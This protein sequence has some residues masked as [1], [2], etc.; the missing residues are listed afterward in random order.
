MPPGIPIATYRLQ[1]SAA[2]TFDDAATLV[3]YLKSLGIS[4]L[5]AS[6]FLKARAGS[7]HGYD[8]VDHNQINPEFGGE[9]GFARLSAAL[10]EADIGLI[11]DFVP[12][13]MGIGYADNA[14]WLD[15]LEWGEKS[16]Y[17]VAFDIEWDLLPHRGGGGVLLPILGSPYGHA[18]ENGD[19]VLKYDGEEGSFSAWYYEHRLP[20]RPDR[21]G[22]MLR[23]IVN[24]AAAGN[25]TAGRRL[26]E[27]AARSR[28]PRR[29]SRAEAPALKA[30]LAAVAGGADVIARGIHIYRPS[31]G[32][33]DS[34]LP[35]HRLLERQHYRVAHWRLAASE[36]NYRRFFDIND[37]AGLRVEDLDTFRRV[38]ALVARLTADNKLQGL[39]LDHIDGLW[40]PIQYCRRLQRLIRAAQGASRRE[41][42]VVVEKIL[43]EG[44]HVPALPGV[45]GTTGYEWLNVISRVLVDSNGLEPL[46]RFRREA[47]DNPRPFRQILERAKLRVLENLLSSEFTV[48]TRLLAR[49]AAGHYRTRDFTITRLE[50]ALRLFVLEF[51]VYRTYVSAAGPAP[52]DRATIDRA[53]RAARARWFGPDVEIFDFLREVL[54]LDL[55]GPGR[56]GYSSARV[57]RFAVKVQQFTGPMMAKSLEDTAFYRYARLVGLNE[58]GADPAV[59]GLSPHEFHRRMLVREAQAPHGLTATAT[60]DTKR[61][62]DARMRVLAIA[63]LTDD[64]A[65]AVTQWRRLN[66][67][68]A[69]RLDNLR[70]P[71]PVLEY[72]LYQ[73]LIGAWPLEAPDASLAE[74]M[75]TYAVKAARE[76]KVETSWINPDEAYEAGVKRFVRR[77]L[78]PG[79]SAD[80]IASFEELA[81]RTALLG[82]LNGLSQLTLKATMPGVP[83]FYQG[84]EFW[85][86]SLVDPD[87]RRPVDFSARAAALAQLGIEPDWAALAAAW[88]D[89]RIKL[90]L[91][92]HLLA[93]RNEHA[94]LFAQG[95]YRPLEVNGPHRDHVVAFARTTGRDAVVVAVG[96]LFSP[97][98]RGGTCWPAAQDWNA[99]LVLDGFSDIHDTLA[100]DKVWPRP[101]L[102]LSRLFDPLPVA[103]MRANL[104]HKATT[105]RRPVESPGEPVVAG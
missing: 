45:A 71:S 21:Y 36:I 57:R 58:V 89:G 56:S 15:V 22:E 18:L 28:G 92:R 41:F 76:G 4:H 7:T 52:E 63:E 8:I 37:L 60:H 105:R 88:P 68:L 99:E 72:L 14:W 40:D 73:T 31:S 97:L 17:A 79:E 19:I 90:A 38:H 67:R 54:T 59:P 29:P 43:A 26:L 48:L 5:Y 91:T 27:L 11:L 84:T 55:V 74:R 95:T 102:P 104:A 13:H 42:Y 98:T 47:T 10:T 86:L 69:E 20:I 65:S 82:A 87:N 3:P 81:R 62:E 75:E 49:I 96:R 16:P 78:D 39:R 61:G 33:P 70:A 46:D 44:E 34:A 64:W 100:P 50:A 35:L 9:A 24:A 53:I 2:F 66:D 93:L 6:P 101:A 32:N 80:F 23:M 77:I 25:E 103:I 1:L 30:A 94:A 83:D 85:D 12:N 51:P